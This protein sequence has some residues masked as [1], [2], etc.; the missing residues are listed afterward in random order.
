M[1]RIFRYLVFLFLSGGILFVVPPFQGYAVA[2]SHKSISHSHTKKKYR[3]RRRRRVGPRLYSGVPL[4]ILSKK[5]SPLS[6]GVTYTEEIVSRNHW[7]VGIIHADLSADSLGLELRKSKGQ[8]TGMERV[9]ELVHRIDSTTDETVVAAVNANYWRGGTDDIMGAAVHNGEVIGF[10]NLK[11][12]S[13]LQIFDDG[14]FGIA[15]D[16]LSVIAIARGVPPLVIARVNMRLSDSS[17]VLYNHYYGATLPLPEPDTS[18]KN[19]IATDSLHN[20]QY[21]KDSAQIKYAQDTSELFYETD[22]V[23]PLPDSLCVIPRSEQYTLKC[24]FTYID[25]PFVNSS[26]RCRIIGFGNS[27]PVN[28]PSRGGVLSFPRSDSAIIHRLHTGDTLTIECVTDPLTT[29]PIKEMLMAGPRLVRDGRVSVE[30][31]EENFHKRSF[32]AG[33]HARTAFGI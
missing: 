15:S 13:R 32:I 22:E 24:A 5:T 18:A 4:K 10:D 11:P 20:I 1:R 8:A 7:R 6:P 14:T 3:Y 21:P 12:W 28:I 26:L 23:T 29:K 27:H 9:E 17:I 2:R 33:S 31:E 16:S 19:F 25:T 30:T